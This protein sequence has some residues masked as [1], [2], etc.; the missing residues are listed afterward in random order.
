MARDYD[1]LFAKTAIQLK[2]LTPAQI[3]SCREV[4]A[5]LESAGV[6]KPLA[7]VSIDQGM[8]SQ[9]DALRVVEAV[10]QR[11]PGKH[12]PLGGSP[13][14]RA[15]R[16]APAAA[17]PLPGREPSGEASPTS[18]SAPGGAR[19]RPRPLPEAR[20]AASAEADRAPRSA[21][22]QKPAPSAA[23]S[24]SRAGPAPSSGKPKGVL[25]AALGGGAV[26]IL[27][28]A[29]LFL[30]GSRKGTA[31][32][33][34]P[35]PPAPRTEIVRERR[36]SPEEPRRETPAP[37]PAPKPEPPA[38]PPRPAPPPSPAP[39]TTG[40][41]YKKQ[42]EDEVAERKKEGQARLEEVKREL[43]QERKQSDELSEAS[44]NRLASQRVSLTLASG[45]AIKNAV[46]RSFT[47][48]GAD[49]EAGGKPLRI[50]W[51]TVQPASLGQIA[52]VMFDPQRAA[53]QFDRG[54]FFVARRRWKDAQAA[55]SAAAK[56]GQGFESRVLEFSEVLDRLASGQGGFRGSARRVGHDGVHLTWDFH[57]AKQLEDFTGGLSLASGGVV[58]ESTRKA[59]VYFIGGTSSGSDESPLD[60]VGDLNVGLKIQS[61]GPVTFYFFMSAT[62]GYELELGSAGISLYKLNP[63]VPEKD[64]RRE[65]AKSTKGRLPTGKPC[66]VRV[67]VS[68]PRISVTLDGTEAFA[69]ED[70]PRSV[71]ADPPKGAF[72]F[73]IEKGKLKIDAPLEI[74]GR[75][76][77]TELDRRIGD[78]EVMVRRALDPELEQIERFRAR[79]KAMALLD[80][81][82][83][84]AISSDHIWFLNRLQPD[85]N[86]YEELKKHIGGIPDKQTPEQWKAEMDALIAKH[87]EVPSLYYVL[88]LFDHEHQDLAG[89][90]AAVEKA[91]G[92]YPEF[93][94][95]LALKSEML[96]N[97]QDPEAALA[98]IRRAIE[99]RPDFVDGYVTLARCVY[100]T[101]GS[102]AQ[103]MEDLDIARKLDPQDSSA[104]AVQRMLKYQSLGPRELGC[105][106]DYET[107]H[108]RVTSDISPEASKRYGDNL[109]AAFRHYMASFK[110]GPPRT[111]RKPRV[112]IFMTAENYYTYFELLS[113]DR[114][115]NTL[116][117]FRPELN[118][119]VLFEKSGDLADTN[120]TL[121]H[122]AVHQFMTLLTNRTPPYWYNEG[123]AEYMGSIKI[124]D[125]KV[126]EKALPLPD[127]LPYAQL[128]IE[129]KADLAFDKIMNETPGEFYSG[130][131]GFKYAQAWSMIHFFYEYEK[132]KYRSL[133]EDY[134]EMLRAGKTPRACFDAIFKVKQED[135]QKEWR[136][137]TMSLKP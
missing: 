52:D 53:D 122:E 13:A 71:T 63:K 27:G 117:V 41:E 47:F 1:D 108:Y 94:E 66:E 77:A 92:F 107:L 83:D 76:E 7:R 119:L 136:T 105:R 127:R 89:G 62:G 28:V 99:A 68:H 73:G 121:Y 44:R 128:A 134:F 18:G 50:T 10:N 109:E 69:A 126:L 5:E 85:F 133:I 38:E 80:E 118:E 114:G 97:R 129:V 75:A 116:G 84:L 61:D 79:R 31:P 54:R 55:F 106:F 60:F 19:L 35:P 3:M 111:G 6:S 8:I 11:E 67:N 100:A 87:P 34:P 82:R 93:Y 113:E 131:V 101:S 78:T 29:W 65:I 72:G 32:E 16:A 37:P 33:A 95:A 36:P 132:G 91:I 26:V 2:L 123:I 81:N 112:S 110:G 43:S 58:L 102:L 46:I 4:L 59:A 56:L 57:D 40:D 115:Q 30:G 9:S 70:G 88:A 39:R 49:L 12:P 137:F 45:E 42:F 96:L 51:D 17:T 120:H 24:A 64:R 22:R 20:P 130:N 125:G 14:T 90:L 86:R 23:R 104:L 103:F 25:F 135:L 15:G 98:A 48:H 74:G 124:R 21:G